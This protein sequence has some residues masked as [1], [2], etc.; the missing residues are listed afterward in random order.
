MPIIIVLFALAAACWLGSMAA[1]GAQY[2]LVLSVGVLSVGALAFFSP[3]LSLI[4]LVFSMLLSP[5]MGG[6]IVDSSRS[7]VVRYDDILLVII[8]L[9]WFARTSIFKDKPFITSTPVQTPILLYTALCFISTAFGVIRGDIDAKASFFYVM[10]YV[11]YFLL[12]FMTVNV[13]ETEAEIKNYMRYGL[14]VAVIVAGYAYYYYYG[15]GPDARATA[16]FE[17]PLGDPRD[18]EPASLGGYFLIVFGIF[19]AMLSESKGYSFLL[20]LG[21]LIFMFPAFLL[22][23]SRSSYIGFTAMF[24][25]IFFLSRRR[26]LFMSGFFSA[27]IVFI[28]IMPNLS[29]KVVERITMTYSGAYATQ[30]FQAGTVGNIKLEDSAASRVYSIKRVLFEKLPKHPVFGWGVTGVGLGDTQYALVLGELGLL[31]AALFAWMMYRLFYTAKTVFRNSKEPVLR[32][33]ALGFMVALVGLLFQA[34]GVNSFIVVR[35]MEPF[36]FMAALLSVAYL[37][38]KKAGDDSSTETTAG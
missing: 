13:V 2:M 36:W 11:E 17:A 33:L 8:F 29:H 12:Y 3:K 18:S 9:S 27:G 15:S 5:E 35:I 31:G 1:A 19:F 24:P 21:M 30:I 23:F 6:G 14:I 34:L 32:V 16:P 25:A 26:R 22:T 20:A 37:K 7:V 4:L 28:A 38:I 10:K